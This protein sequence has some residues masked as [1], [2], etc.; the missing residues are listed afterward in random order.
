V[1]AYALRLA[2]GV[3]VAMPAPNA[4]VA[5]KGVMAVR[6]GAQQG[7]AGAIAAAITAALA[8]YA[9]WHWR[10]ARAQEQPA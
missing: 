7:S 8:A 4:A 9:F 10:Q 5:G 6:K 2:A 1:K 3:D